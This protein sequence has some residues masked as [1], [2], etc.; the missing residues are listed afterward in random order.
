MAAASVVCPQQPASTMSWPLPY[1]SLWAAPI[2]HFRHRLKQVLLTALI[3]L[4]ESQN[5]AMKTHTLWIS[6]AL[7]T[8][9]TLADG[10]VLLSNVVGSGAQRHSVTFY[11]GTG[12]GTVP[13]QDPSYIAQLYVWYGDA[14][15][16]A[17][18]PTSEFGDLG[19]I[20]QATVEPPGVTTR[21]PVWA[22]IRCWRPT[23]GDTFEQAVLT[24]GFGGVSNTVFVHAGGPS[25]GVPILAAEW[26]GLDYP[27]TPVV[28][29]NPSAQV[30]PSSKNLNLSVVA[31]SGVKMGYQWF[32][33]PSDRPDGLI[34]DATN[35]VI[36]IHPAQTA[37]YWVKVSNQAGETL[38][39]PATIT[40]VSQPPSLGFA[41]VGGDPVVTVR[42]AAGLTVQVERS[43][44]LVSGP[45]NPLGVV[46]GTGDPVTL[47]D[48]GDPLP[49]ARFHRAWVV[50]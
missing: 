9:R 22:Q 3:R 24:G 18:E 39:D 20:R 49:D 42:A 33:D 16:Q 38:S 7:A 2:R 25:G 48:T 50:R 41:W 4:F 21:S 44:D 34:P 43:A 45:W 32:Q 46:V 11:D 19:I 8:L 36:T 29:R 5:K 10:T 17:V 37:I 23:D 26:V 13:I 15:F 27:G 1:G 40:V 35:S 14:G 47:V 28:V 6:L 12:D 31:A 30:I